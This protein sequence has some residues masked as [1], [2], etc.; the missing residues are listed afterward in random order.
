M[1]KMILAA[2]MMAC[3]IA[4]GAQTVVKHIQ[5]D[6]SFLAAGV[7][8]GD[9]YYMSGTM[10][11]PITPGDPAKGVAPDYGNTE[12]QAMSILTKIQAGLK[13][14][15]LDMKDVVKVTVFL[16]GD[17]KLDGKIDFSGLN[18]SFK[19]FFGTA[20]QPNKPAR[21][22]VQVAHLVAPWAL[23]EIE[24]IAVRSK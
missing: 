4:A 10:A 13:A 17:P 19:K 18:T 3:S 5:D 16:A 15:G 21:S 1:K 6:K 11:S 9:T 20:E 23:L 2:A 8:A 24:V 7:W 14:Q 22:A 12:Q